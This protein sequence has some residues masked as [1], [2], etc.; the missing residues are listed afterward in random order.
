VNGFGR[1]E[2]KQKKEKDK[3]SVMTRETVGMTLLLFSAVIF[4][5]TVT[6]KYVF[7]EI[8]VAITLFFLGLFGFLAYPL[9]LFIIYLSVLL[10]FG[11]KSIPVKWMLRVW[12]FVLSVFFI[13][14]TATGE[15]FFGNG[16]GAYLSGC[17]GAASKS[18]AQATGGGILLGL[19]VFP[20]RYLL[21]AAGAYIFFS[22]L[23]LLSVFVILMGTPL[24]ARI[25]GLKRTPRAPREDAEAKSPVSFDDLEPTRRPLEDEPPREPVR[26]AERA[27][28]PMSFSAP[29]EPPQ[30]ARKSDYER[31]KEILFGKSKA[32]SYRENLTFDHD[33]YYNR[34][35]RRQYEEQ[36]TRNTPV[37]PA[38]PPK[39]TSYSES[40]NTEAE[41]PRAQM[42]R[43]VS[44]FESG[45]SGGYVYSPAEDVSYPQTPSYH[46]E[47]APREPERNRYENDVPYDEEY[48]SAPNVFDEPKKQDPVKPK[49]AARRNS[50]S[51]NTRSERRERDD[52]DDAIETLFSRSGD[53]RA[54]FGEFSDRDTSRGADEFS[55]RRDDGFASRETLRGDD[56]FSRNDDFTARDTTR[57][58][59]DFSSRRDESAEGGRDAFGGRSFD[60]SESTGG[61]SRVFDAGMRS[62]SEMFDDDEIED[63]VPE[64]PEVPQE[65]VRRAPVVRSYEPEEPAPKP[66]HVYKRYVPPIPELL[67]RYD[68]AN[69]VSNEEIETNSAIIVDTLASFRIDAEVVRVTCGSAVTRYDIDIPMNTPVNMVTKRSAELAMHLRAAKGVNVYANLEHGAISIEVPNAHRAT[70]G[71][72][73]IVQSETFLNTKPTALSFAIGK[74][75]DGRCV[76]GDITEMTHILVAGTTGSGKSI[77]LHTLICSMLYKYSPEELRIILIDPKKNEFTI[78]EGLPHLMIN[79]IIS[80]PQK[81]VMALNWAIKEMERRYSLFQ[82]KTRSGIACRNI[83][84]YNAKITPDEERLPKIVIVTDELADLMS[85]AKKDIEERIQ[86]LAQKARAA[87]IHLVLATQRPS[88]DVVTGVIKSNLPTRMA[89]SVSSEVDSRVILDESGAEKLLGLGDMIFTIGGSKRTRAQ[90]AFVSSDETQAIVGFIKENNEAYFDESVSDYVNKQN[91]SEGGGAY[92]GDDDGGEVD[93]QYIKALGIVVKLGTASISLIQ[94]KCAV[95][96]NHAGKIIEWME[97][98]GYISAFDGKAKART[99]LL[100]KEEYE[101]KY[102][103]LD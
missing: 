58:D 1:G 92:G 91:A 68:D 61:D 69:N 84:E 100:T 96:Y 47:N 30:P 6:G 5:I 57:G 45:E 41:T 70:V 19:I 32:D 15:R 81:A 88:V 75:I 14:Q 62:A 9:M 2:N 43:K 34:R 23:L 73:S 56:D 36:N 22:L 94:R 66:R 80:D 103:S 52:G 101:S 71:M 28:Q 16:Y 67:K 42:P 83:D 10:V 51:R 8:G 26:Q 99:V 78:Y 12:F 37:P 77:C 27:R 86:R 97:L 24:K 4:F 7:G 102:G 31:S 76:C 95:G 46:A 64:V 85:V 74:D 59:D 18:A 89:L 13:V 72:R 29:A 17:W 38:E 44:S 63:E 79:E 65:P 53:E 21:S 20:V 98:M 35:A 33:S 25:K 39:A 90:G 93:Q 3:A 87:G 55:D 40:W 82:E 11:K 48:S 50:A 60:R 49:P 54:D